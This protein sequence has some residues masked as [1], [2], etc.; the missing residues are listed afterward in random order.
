MPTI[1]VKPDRDVDFY[2]GWSSVVDA[3]VWFGSRAEVLEDDGTRSLGLWENV[4]GETITRLD[5]ADEFGT[6]ALY[7]DPRDGG[8]EDTGFVFMN[9]GWLPRERLR[10]LADRLMLDENDPCT[11]L[12]D[13]FEDEE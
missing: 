11:D 5:R 1:I 6:S 12:L 7:G 13:P 2:L 3:P 8:W 10:T 4:P 9:C